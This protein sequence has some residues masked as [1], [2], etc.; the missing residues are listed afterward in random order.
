MARP[1]L[2][3]PISRAGSLDAGALHYKDLVLDRLA[4][5][6]NVAQFVSFGPGQEPQLRYIRVSDPPSRRLSSMTEAIVALLERSVEHSVNVRSFE[7]AQPKAHEF[8]YGLSDSDTV[9]QAVRRL[10]A[11]GLYTI[12]NET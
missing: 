12:V 11:Q 2:K 3:L 8:I 5:S 6:A 4:E 1:A 10:A 9:T 7:P